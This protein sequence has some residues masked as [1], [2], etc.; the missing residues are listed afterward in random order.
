MPDYVGPE[1]RR[2][3]LELDEVN[4]KLASVER[5]LFHVAEGMESFVSTDEIDARIGYE[6]SQRNKLLGVMGVGIVVVVASL[7]VNIA[8]LRDLHDRSVANRSK[9]SAAAAVTINAVDCILASLTI[10]REAN[11]F[12]HHAIVSGLKVPYDE[13]KELVPP[14]LTPRLAGACDA[15]NRALAGRGRETP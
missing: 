14:E 8:Q 1:R 2:T 4:A 7:G 15:F 10:H 11:E 3:N 13:P 6:R 9:N 12:A 5:A